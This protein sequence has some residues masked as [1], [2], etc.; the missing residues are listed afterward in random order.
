MLSRTL[1]N[2]TVVPSRRLLSTTAPTRVAESSPGK[3][4]T[5][6][7]DTP[8]GTKDPFKTVSSGY[9]QSDQGVPLENPGGVNP[10]EMHEAASNTSA[11]GAERPK[12]MQI[13]QGLSETTKTGVMGG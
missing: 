6:S 7:Y 11:E 2:I 12:E 1:R 3:L 9:P 10:E 5:S 13:D 4:R 8:S